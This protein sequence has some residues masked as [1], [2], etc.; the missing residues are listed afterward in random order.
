M[1]CP[2]R[3]RLLSDILGFGLLG[4][5]DFQF[6]LLF[7][8]H[9]LYMSDIVFTQNHSQQHGIEWTFEGRTI[10]SLCLLCAFENLDDRGQQGHLLSV[11]VKKILNELIELFNRRDAKLVGLVADV[12]WRL[13]E[14]FCRV[15][16]GMEH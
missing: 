8:Q 3:L 6:Q 10:P 7:Y 2:S 13:W 14:H 4:S 11:F 1:P 5:I 9:N 12:H 16:I 15:L